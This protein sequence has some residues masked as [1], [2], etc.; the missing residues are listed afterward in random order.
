MVTELRLGSTVRQQPVGQTPLG[1]GTSQCPGGSQEWSLACSPLHEMPSLWLDPLT[2]QA[3][4]VSVL[5]ITPL[6]LCES[7]PRATGVY[8]KLSFLFHPTAWESFL[9]PWCIGIILPILFSMRIVPH[10]DVVF[11]CLWGEVSSTSSYSVLIPLPI[12]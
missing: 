8:L 4:H 11:M 5:V 3:G 7:H 9:H 6:L 10:I 2:P 1:L 12:I